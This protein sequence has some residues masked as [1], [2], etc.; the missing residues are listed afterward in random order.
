MA[1]HSGKLV[2]KLHIVISSSFPPN[3]ILSHLQPGAHHLLQPLLTSSSDLQRNTQI[4]L[5]NF[6][7]PTCSFILAPNSNRHPLGTCYSGQKNREASVRSSLSLL[8]SESNPTFS[9]SSSVADYSCGLLSFWDPMP[10]ELSRSWC[11]TL[12]SSLFPAYHHS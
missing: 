1:F 11:H 9:S 2:C 5:S 10:R 4:S 7:S 12:L 3:P 8:S 6:L